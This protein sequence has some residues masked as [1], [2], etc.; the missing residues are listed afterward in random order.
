MW[1]KPWK[2]AEGIAIGAGL[3]LVGLL[4]QA[5]IGPIDWHLLAFPL[6]AILLTVYL[7]ALGILYALRKQLYVVEWTMTMYAAVP[8][9]AFCVIVTLV[10]GLMGWD[11]MLRSWPFA[12]C[13]IWLM[14]VLGLVILRRIVHITQGSIVR[15]LCFLCN[16]LGLFMAMVCGTLGHADMQKLRLTAKVDEPQW[17]AIDLAGSQMPPSIIELPL[18]VELHKFTIDEYPPKY[19]VISNETGRITDD[20][21]WTVRQDSLWEYAAIVYGRRDS[22]GNQDMDRYVE[23]P[24]MGDCTAG[25]VTATRYATAD[26]AVAG[27]GTVV[28]TK[29]GWVSCGSFMFPYKALWLD[30]LYSVVMPEREPRRFASDVTVYTANDRKVDGVIEVNKPLEVEGWKIYQVSY[31]QNLGR[32]SDTSVFEL[33]R[34]PWLPW[35]YAGIFMMLA[36]AVL[37]FITAGKNRPQ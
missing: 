19:A 16:H 4:L 28:E 9:I 12:L 25:Y 37:M 32:W 30:S 34:D 24:S 10:M 18:A 33:V 2:F 6:N 11:Q 3:I 13:Y 15:N 8:A 35:V 17:R 36:G 31:D 26:E 29:Q 5:S 14:N 20:T 27:S 1:S 22:L 23:W 21:P 7:L